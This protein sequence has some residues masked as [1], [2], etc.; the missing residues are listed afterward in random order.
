[1]GSFLSGLLA[2]DAQGAAS[3]V[4]RDDIAEV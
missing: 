3:V 1:M 2:G 4:G